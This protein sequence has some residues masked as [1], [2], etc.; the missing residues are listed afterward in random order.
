MS[1]NT[2]S[3]GLAQ[4]IEE[5]RKK[6]P[7]TA[8]DDWVFSSEAIKSPVC[9]YNVWRRLLASRL[10]Q[11]G[12]A[13]VTFQ[14]MGRTHSSL[15]RELDV[16]PEIRAQQMGHTVD[17]NENVYTKTSLESRRQAV[18]LLEAALG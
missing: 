6:S 15:L 17:V 10:E 12:L 16:S 3:D 13:W 14:V 2:L 9:P 7:C 5:W 1:P 18:N 8:P 11:A 4:A